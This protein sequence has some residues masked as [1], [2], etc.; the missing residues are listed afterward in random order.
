VHGNEIAI[1]TFDRDHRYIFYK[2]FVLTGPP[3]A[4]RGVMDYIT[5][6]C[7]VSPSMEAGS[8]SDPIRI[9]LLTLLALLS[10]GSGLIAQE[11]VELANVFAEGD[12]AP[13]V[14]APAEA[15]EAEPA[16]S[17]DEVQAL[18]ARLE[19]LEQ[20]EKKRTAAEAKKAAEAAKVDDWLDLSTEKWTVK[21][22]GHV[23]LDYINWAHA[24][25]A[26]VG[27]RDYFAYR[28]LR[29]VADG[30]GYGVFDFRLQMTLEPGSSTGLPAGTGASRKLLRAVR[31]GAGHERHEQYL[32]GALDPDA[33]GIHR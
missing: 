13:V 11:G 8:M 30:T 12:D 4:N 32:H 7:R 21:L 20:A 27:A 25:D 10:M 19:L 6:V 3:E 22:G 31:S 24:D 1:T 28:R 29:L 23:Q 26:I 16:S 15:A 17:A 18:R 14:A 5:F 2:S 33:G 9:C